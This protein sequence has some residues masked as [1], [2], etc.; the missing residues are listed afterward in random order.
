MF[1]DVHR[2]FTDHIRAA[3]HVSADSLGTYFNEAESEPDEHAPSEDELACDSFLRGSPI[4]LMRNMCLPMGLMNGTR[5]RIELQER[6]LPHMHLVV[7][8]RHGPSTVEDIDNIVSAEIPD[9]LLE[10]DLH[11][12]PSSPR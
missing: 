3:M 7:T 9:P 5:L 10:P 12:A 2:M 8:L 4:M 11:A 6:G 1:T